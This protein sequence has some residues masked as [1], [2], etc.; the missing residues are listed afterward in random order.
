MATEK[1][2]MTLPEVIKL[3]TLSKPTIYSYIRDGRFPRQIRI[4]PGRVVW[5]RADVMKYL[6]S[7][8]QEAA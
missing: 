2:V 5:R 7:D 8:S 1:I 3:T 4:G 6:E